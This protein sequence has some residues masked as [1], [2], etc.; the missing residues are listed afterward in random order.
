MY[1]KCLIIKCS[2]GSGNRTRVACLEGRNFTIKLYPR[3][4]LEKYA[5]AEGS[6]NGYCAHST[7]LREQ[8]YA[9]GA[10]HGKISSAGYHQ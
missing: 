3:N 6:V 4:F 8:I 9:D 5:S 2:A 7:H 10:V 1:R